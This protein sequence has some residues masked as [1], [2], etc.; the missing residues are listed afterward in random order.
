M[1]T[2]I[3]INLVE[4]RRKHLLS[5]NLNESKIYP[6][7]KTYNEIYNYENLKDSINNWSFYSESMGRNL[8]KL[9]ELYTLVATKGTDSQLREI[10]NFL[11]NT[12]STQVEPALRGCFL[13]SCVL[14]APNF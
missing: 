4:K 14:T 5:K 11:K 10:T 9:M 8:S 12:P 1:G 13:L 2:A 7:Y 3:P 6:L